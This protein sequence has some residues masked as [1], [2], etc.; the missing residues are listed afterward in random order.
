MLVIV[1]ALKMFV[2]AMAVIGG[3]STPCYL[4]MR[5]GRK[6]TKTFIETSKD[7]V[8]VTWA[9]VTII[10]LAMCLII[11]ALDPSGPQQSLPVFGI[12]LCLL[13]FVFG[14]CSQ[15]K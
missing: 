11:A 5:L 12:G 4:G 2:I 15:I 8:K 13:S 14:T 9:A 1:S 7:K 6:L 10:V 3:I